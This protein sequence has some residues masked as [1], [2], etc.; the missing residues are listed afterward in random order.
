MYSPR[1][2]STTSTPRASRASLRWVSSDTIDLLLTAQLAPARSAIAAMIRLAWSGV[3]AQW[4]CAPLAIK[5]ASNFSRLSASVRMASSLAARAA[6]RQASAP[7]SVPSASSRRE[8]SWLVARV[9]AARRCAS[10]SA[11]LTRTAKSPDGSIDRSLCDCLDRFA[12][13]VDAEGHDVAR[14]EVDGRRFHPQSD[15][16]RRAG[17]DDVAWQQGHELTQVTD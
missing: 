8:P 14:P 4:T 13:A 16:G 9:T 15:A 11:P 10:A 3:S 12:E 1:S 2:V 17:A 6:S 7:S 5:R